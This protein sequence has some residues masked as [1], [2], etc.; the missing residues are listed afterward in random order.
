MLLILFANM[1]I[2]SC[3]LRETNN[4][5]L[6][7]TSNLYSLAQIT[8]IVTTINHLSSKWA[9]VSQFGTVRVFLKW[10]PENDNWRSR[11]FVEEGKQET[12]EI[13]LLYICQIVA[14]GS[15]D[16]L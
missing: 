7:S 3:N 4:E 8:P 1:F 10:Y 12:E 11:D 2:K 16:D 9:S 13:N 15:D 5:V 6:Y 14:Y